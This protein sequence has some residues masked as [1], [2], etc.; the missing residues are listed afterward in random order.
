MVGNE[1]FL[2][3]TLA[4]SIEPCLFSR[5]VCT[6]CDLKFEVRYSVLD[7]IIENYIGLWVGLL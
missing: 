6:I 2:L 5:F 1:R 7:G 4:K 3:E